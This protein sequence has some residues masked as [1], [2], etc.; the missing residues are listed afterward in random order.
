MVGNSSITELGKSTLSFARVFTEEAKLE[1]SDAMIER[2]KACG[3]ASCSTRLQL[4][5]LSWSL[6]TLAQS[7]YFRVARFSGQS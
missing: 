7:N 3:S 1:M 2:L 5:T 4:R 6:A